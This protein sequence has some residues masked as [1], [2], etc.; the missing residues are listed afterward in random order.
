MDKKEYLNE[1][2]ATARPVAKPKKGIFSSK[3]F[4][5]GIASV[6]ALI[7]IIII[8]ALISGSNTSIK[9]RISGLILHLDNVSEII[10]EYQPKV[11]SSKLRSSGSSLKSLLGQASK[12]L[13]NYATE[14][15]KYKPSS[16]DKAIVNKETTAKDTL[17]SDLFNAKINGDLDHTFAYK[18]AYEISYIKSQEDRIIKSTSNDNLK[19]ILKSSQESLTNLYDSFNNFSEAN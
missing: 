17:Y 19:E 2:S 15:Y 12:D 11:K 8:G 10:D 16:V 9:D 6:V 7:I 14:K 1:I 3:F 4:W 18:M 13:T 5:I